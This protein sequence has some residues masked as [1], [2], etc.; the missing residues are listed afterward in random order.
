MVTIENVM[1]PF[2]EL[3]DALHCTALLLIRISG[4]SDKR[5]IL[6]GYTSRAVIIIRLFLVLQI[7]GFFF[8][9]L[10]VII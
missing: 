4:T 1:R 5:Q 9:L 3:C 10:T 7:Y 8:I 6:Y 2:I